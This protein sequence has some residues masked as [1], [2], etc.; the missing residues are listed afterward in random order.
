MGNH[1]HLQIETLKANLSQVIQWLNVSW[2]GWSRVIGSKM[3]ILTIILGMV[4][5]IAAIAGV[6]SLF[7][8]WLNLLGIFVPPIG[9]DKIITPLSACYSSAVN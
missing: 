4:G 1:Y 9:E 3:R 7:L 5:A 8:A 6:W 2:M